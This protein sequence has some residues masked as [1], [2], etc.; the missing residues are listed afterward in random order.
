MLLWDCCLD[1][2]LFFG[3]SFYIS[4]NEKVE[5]NINNGN[6]FFLGGLVIEV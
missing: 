4:G 2:E 3:G 1:L 6:I 5:T